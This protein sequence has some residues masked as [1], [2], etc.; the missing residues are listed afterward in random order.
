MRDILVDNKDL[1]IVA[2]V[3]STAQA[4][5]LE[6]VAEGVESLGHARK[7]ADLGVNVL[8][9]FAVAQPMPAEDILN[10]V[11]HYKPILRE[12]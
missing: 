9:G 5:G 12:D 1:A 8:Q 3:A 7:L 11:A 10:W 2:G 6:I 4:L